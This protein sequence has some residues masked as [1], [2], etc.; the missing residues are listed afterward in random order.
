MPLPIDPTRILTIILELRQ[1]PHDE[2]RAID[3]GLLLSIKQTLQEH[4]REVDKALLRLAFVDDQQL[5]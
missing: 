3:R 2:L 5:N 1:T 4:R